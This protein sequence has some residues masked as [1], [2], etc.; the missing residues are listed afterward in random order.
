V[1]ALLRAGGVELITLAEHYG[2]PADE[3]VED[4]EWIA[5]TASRGWIAFMKDARI[6]RRPAEQ[7]AIR[8]HA[9]RCFCLSNANLRSAEMAEQYLRNLPRIAWACRQPGPFIYA[10]R[11]SGIVRLAL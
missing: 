3:S 10:V 11:A 6:R 2:I 4:V 5:E 8:H 1:P 7:D 9:A